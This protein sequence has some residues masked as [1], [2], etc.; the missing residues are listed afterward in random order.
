MDY[1][2]TLLVVV[3]VFLGGFRVGLSE[4]DEVSNG[5]NFISW[6]D[7]KVAK[8]HLTML[9]TSGVDDHDTPAESPGEEVVSPANQGLVI[10]VDKNGGGDSFTV[11][12]AIDMV[13]ENND[14]RVKIYIR[15][16]IYSE[17]VIV[18]SH[19]PYIS[20]VGSENQMSN[21]IISWNNKA[22]DKD[23]RGAN[24]GTYRSASVAI[25]SDYFC[26]TEI[27]IENTAITALGD[28]GNQA[29]ALRISGD[30]AMFYKV[31]VVGNQDTLLDDTGS[32]Y[33]LQCHILGSVD[34][35]FGEA[36]SLYQDCVIESTAE[37]DGA[38]SAHH[39]DLPD[40][41]TGFSFVNCTINGTGEVYLGRAWAS[42]SRTIYSN[43]YLDSVIV[44]PG[45][46]DWNYPDR[47]KYI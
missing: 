13:P 29:V 40:D 37:N 20:F 14:Q 30:K 46:S 31:K 35:I 9:G 28:S 24:L 32:H 1:I 4:T 12:G 39:R 11:Q 10:I 3:I 2:C 26:A 33:F 16:G 38:I 8:Q 7:M 25:E 23:I 6:D 36:R 47:Q 18:P 42:Y 44:P 43:C 21:T 34:F 27:T 22:S 17:K 19:K 41:N 5:K 15:P 45:W